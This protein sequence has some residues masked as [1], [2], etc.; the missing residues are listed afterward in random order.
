MISDFFFYISTIVFMIS[1]FNSHV[2]TIVFMAIPIVI[3]S[4]NASNKY[5]IIITIK[6]YYY[7]F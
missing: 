4:F 2:K 3:L 5:I 7:L 1:N 6:T